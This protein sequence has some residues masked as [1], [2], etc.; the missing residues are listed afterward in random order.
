VAQEIIG[1]PKKEVAEL[2]RCYGKSCCR[3]TSS[4][5]VFQGKASPAQGKFKH[6]SAI[7]MPSR[8]KWHRNNHGDV[9]DT[10][11]E[12]RGMVMLSYRS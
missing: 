8:P 5:A 11:V 1:M 2:M 4:V 6:I 7:S 3:A 10:P 9:K 12:G